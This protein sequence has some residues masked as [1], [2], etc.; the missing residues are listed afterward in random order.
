MVD[1]SY[2]DLARDL[3]EDIARGVGVPPM[4]I[5]KGGSTHTKTCSELRKLGVVKRCIC[6]RVEPR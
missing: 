2:R 4:I 1:G 5:G 3:Q 6:P